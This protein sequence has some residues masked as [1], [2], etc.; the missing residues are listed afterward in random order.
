MENI[1][2]PF[3]IPG[4]R[5]PVKMLSHLSCTFRVRWDKHFEGTNQHNNK[6]SCL[7]F[8]MLKHIL[9][10][11]NKIKEPGHQFVT[12]D[13]ICQLLHQGSL[14]ALPVINHIGLVFWLEIIHLKHFS[15]IFTF[16]LYQS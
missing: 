6:G 1:Y 14:V 7:C 2:L 9:L 4:N 13:P 16:I 15:D 3:I 12:D 10:F 8:K 11:E 5:E